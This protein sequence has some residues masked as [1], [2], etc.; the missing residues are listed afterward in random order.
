[1]LHRRPNILPELGLVQIP[2]RSTYFDSFRPPVEYAR[3]FKEDADRTAIIMHTSGSTNMPKAC[4]A[5][6]S[7]LCKANLLC[8]QPIYQS[9]RIWTEPLPCM[10]GP[11][12]FTTTPLFHVRLGLSH[13]VKGLISHARNTGRNVRFHA[14]IQCA[15][16][17]VFLLIAVLHHCREHCR[18]S[19]RLQGRARFSISSVYP[20]ASVWRRSLP[21]SVEKHEDCK[22]RRCAIGKG[23]GRQYGSQRR[24][25]G[26]PIGIK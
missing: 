14:F 10:P 18:L 5:A 19:E 13:K 9:H 16:Y 24:Q 17:H 2:S 25:A 12:A 15:V 26:E 11:A 20:T 8:V 1:M 4:F 22:H 23:F 6:L 21:G 3:D 7:R